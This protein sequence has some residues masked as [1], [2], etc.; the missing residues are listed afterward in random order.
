M[1]VDEEI[2]VPPTE[3]VR[4]SLQVLKNARDGE[5]LAVGNAARRFD[6]LLLPFARLIEPF[7]RRATFVQPAVEFALTKLSK[8]HQVVLHHMLV[9]PKDKRLT[10]RRDFAFQDLQAEN[11]VSGGT[12]RSVDTIEANAFEKLA[13]LLVSEDFAS[14]FAAEQHLAAEPWPYRPKRQPGI[15]QLHSCWALEFDEEDPRLHIAHQAIELQAVLPEQRVHGQRYHTTGTDPAPRSLKVLTASKGHKHLGSL[16]DVV[17]GDP[18]HFWIH[19]FHF[20]HVLDMGEKQLLCW[21]EEWYDANASLKPY[22]TRIVRDP[23]TETI[24]LAVR[25]RQRHRHCFAVA[26]VV[27]APFDNREVVKEWALEPNEDGWLIE[28]FTELGVGLQYGIYLP[29]LDLYE[30]LQ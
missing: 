6:L 3:G 8:Q 14:E 15:A 16:P 29:G 1:P 18:S 7:E 28:R 13:Q 19:F 27:K 25:L 10:K 22:L 20:G 23:E 12:S 21:R 11:L 9:T 24:G 5:P 2:P 4:E 26:R 30:G 17:P